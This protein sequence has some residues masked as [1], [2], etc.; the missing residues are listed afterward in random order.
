MW[1][2]LSNDDVKS[3][4]GRLGPEDL[5]RFMCVSKDCKTV[6]RSDHCWSRHVDKIRSEYRAAD[7][8]DAMREKA[9]DHVGFLQ[10]VLAPEYDGP[11]LRM[12]YLTPFTQRQP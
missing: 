9:F 10:S 7:S 5:A 1:S 3:V 2:D 11:P 4:L 6:G 12:P 8:E